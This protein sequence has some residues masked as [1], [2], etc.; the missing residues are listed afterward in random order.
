M[1]T[2][3]IHPPGLRP[4]IVKEFI[5]AVHELCCDLPRV[6]GDVIMVDYDVFISGFSLL[7]DWWFD[8]ISPDEIV[9]I[10]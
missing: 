10:V 1:F 6:D 7:R 2:C 3:L 9:L 5:Y 8:H 4:K